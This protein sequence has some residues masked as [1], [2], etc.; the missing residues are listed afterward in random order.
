MISLIQHFEAD[1]LW[2]VILKILNL[3]IILKTFTHV[4]G[5]TRSSQLQ[6]IPLI[7]QSAR[8]PLHLHAVPDG[9]SRLP[10]WSKIRW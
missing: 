7:T 6:F 2:K 10:Q 8:S 4:D 1:F 9:Q 5:A 3:G